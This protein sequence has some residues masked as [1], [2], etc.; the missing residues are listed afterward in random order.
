MA[1][2]QSGWSAFTQKDD[3]KKKKKFTI[4]GEGAGQIKTDSKGK[5]YAI[6]G[7]PDSDVDIQ[8]YNKMMGGGTD[9]WTGNKTAMPGD[10]IFPGSP[11]HLVSSMP[12][13]T[14]PKTG[15][16]TEPDYEK[17]SKHK[18]DDY[19]GGG[20][21]DAVE[22]EDSKKRKKGPRSYRTIK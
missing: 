6:Y 7:G 1:Y 20:S 18:G 2:K 21:W 9:P 3:D 11:G 5:K 22:T 15:K 13:K 4:P 17:Q 19:I 10:T 14:D 8:A 16:F 12:W